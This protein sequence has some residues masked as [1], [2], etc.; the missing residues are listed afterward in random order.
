MP[1]AGLDVCERNLAGDIA[2]TA[3]VVECIAMEK[4]EPK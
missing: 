1:L 4:T 3:A 2:V